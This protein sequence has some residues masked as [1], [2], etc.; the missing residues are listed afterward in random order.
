MFASLRRAIAARGLTRSH[1]NLLEYNTV[2]PLD[3]DDDLQ[4]LKSLVEYYGRLLLTVTRGESTDD[5]S[6]SQSTTDSERM[7]ESNRR[8]GW[9]EDVRPPGHDYCVVGEPGVIYDHP[10]FSLCMAIE[11][12][13]CTWSED[14]LSTPSSTPRRRRRSTKSS[15]IKGGY[16]DASV[17]PLAL[18][19]PLS[20]ETNS[21]YSVDDSSATNSL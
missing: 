17:S 20:L 5:G 9:V 2:F 1:S 11:M 13:L 14:S 12:P 16:S 10:S 4:S 15:K 18:P 7:E 3:N 8:S 19:L 21:V 6:D